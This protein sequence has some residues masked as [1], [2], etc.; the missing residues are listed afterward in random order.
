VI[1]TRFVGK[2]KSSLA[3]YIAPIISHIYRIITNR[4]RVRCSLVIHGS[5]FRYECSL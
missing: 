4:V 5:D 1:T 2:Y 3:E